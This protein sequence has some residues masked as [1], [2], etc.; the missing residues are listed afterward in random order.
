MAVSN[1]LLGFFRASGSEDPLTD[2]K[3]TQSWFARQ[4]PNDYLATSEAMVRTLED[5]G[6]RQPKISQGRVLALME[7][8]RLATPIHARL[9]KQYLQTSLSD[10]IRQRLWHALDDLARWF[11]YSYENLFEAM[12]GSP[13]GQRMREQM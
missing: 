3:S 10:S 7:L 1:T 4:P 2:V 9:L 13:A 8:D 12:L 6:A 11:A 5:L